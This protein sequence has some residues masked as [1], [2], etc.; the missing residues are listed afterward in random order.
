MKW[1]SYVI[2]SIF[3]TFV[4]CYLASCVIFGGYYIVYS[5]IKFGVI[6]FYLPYSA[7]FELS[8]RAAFFIGVA[9]VLHVIFIQI[10]NSK[11]SKKSSKI[12]K[13]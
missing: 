9:L 10:P 6:K 7:I 1:I 13:K 4:S 12:N 8:S 3:I 2:Y 11:I 5:K